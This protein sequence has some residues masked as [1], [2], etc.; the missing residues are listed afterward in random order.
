VQVNDNLDGVIQSGIANNDFLQELD[1]AITA[2]PG[3]TITQADIDGY[4]ALIDTALD[5]L[6][7]VEHRIAGAMSEVLDVRETT[8]ALLLQEKNAL[9]D[10]QQ[11]D[12]ASAII[13][14][15]TRQTALEAAERAYARTAGLS[16][17]SFLS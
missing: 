14:L 3:S 17:F 7:L 11:V 8:N 10:I 6:A 12:Q 4:M 15:Q 1:E 13:E 5:N 9:S 16:L 2:L